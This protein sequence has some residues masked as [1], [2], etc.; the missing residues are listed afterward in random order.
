[1]KR[2]SIVIT[3]G[4]EEPDQ[5]VG[6]DL[7]ALVEHGDPHPDARHELD[8]RRGPIGFHSSTQEDPRP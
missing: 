2:L 4:R 8:G 6:P 7:D 3:W 5:P 1:M